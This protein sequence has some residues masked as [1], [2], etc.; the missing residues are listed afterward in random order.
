M[1]GPTITSIKKKKLTSIN[2]FWQKRAPGIRS[3][4]QNISRVLRYKTVHN[5]VQKRPPLASSRNHPN[6]VH[7]LTTPFI[8]TSILSL[9][10]FLGHTGGLF[11]SGFATKVLWIQLQSWKVTPSRLLRHHIQSYPR[12]LKA[13]SSRHIHAMATINALHTDS[14]S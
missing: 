9:H 10:Q 3:A 6:S 2:N 11:P 8:S 12:Y 1:E 4:G 7:I 5:H 13:V 14:W